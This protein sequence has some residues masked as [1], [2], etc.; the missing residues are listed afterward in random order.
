MLLATYNF[1]RVINDIR[2]NCHWR[3]SMIDEGDEGD[4]GVHVYS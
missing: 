4:K 3:G 2:I 1:E